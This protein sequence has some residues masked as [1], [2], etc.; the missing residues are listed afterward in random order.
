MDINALKKAVWQRK[1]DK[2]PRKAGTGHALK[3][4]EL[5]D[6]L[7]EH[8]VIADAGMSVYT[9][10]GLS[11]GCR[12]CKDGGWLCIFAGYACNLSCSFCPQE[13][14]VKADKKGYFRNIKIQDI[15]DCLEQYGKEYFRGLSY[16]GG[17]PFLFLD[18]VLSF[19][20]FVAGR[21]PHIYQWLYTNGLLAGR[22]QLKRL[23]GSGIN[24]IRI[25]LLA[26]NFSKA[27][28][29]KLPAA[30]KYFEFLSVEIPSLP[31]VYDQLINKKM[32]HRL[33]E[34]GVDQL[35]LAEMCL[36]EHNFGNY[37][38][39]PVYAYR[40]DF[41]TG[42]SPVDSRI[43]TYKIMKYAIDNK[44]KMVINDCSNDAKLLQNKNRLSN[45]IITK[46][47]FD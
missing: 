20:K 27:V 29:K 37:P 38:A 41:F 44:L 35:N 11:K 26:S 39:M 22:D 15:K 4:K 33:E 45:P 23:A 21:W 19:S 25:D 3:V 10:G 42:M 47:N 1:L 24:E 30:R 9:K 13:H 7:R 31:G 6:G 18:S 36:T 28:M 16:S 12:A 34:S 32:I 46:L 40:S 14:F 5:Q 17:E 8:L 43:L 2:L